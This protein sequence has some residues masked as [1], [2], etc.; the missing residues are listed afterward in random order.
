MYIATNKHDSAYCPQ[1]FAGKR[2]MVVGLG[3][4]GLSVVRFLQQRGVSFAV[5]D[6][7]VQPPGLTNLKEEFPDVPVFLGE[8]DPQVFASIDVLVVSPG[9]AVATPVIAACAQRGAEIIGDIEI[10]ARCNQ[11][12]VIAITGSNGKSTVTSLVA[13]MVRQAGYRVAAGANLGIPA[14][15]LLEQDAD[16]YVLELSSFQLET[17]TSLNASVSTILNISE[18]HMDRYA[19]LAD[20][21]RAKAAIFTG[22]GV[23]ISNDD[24]PIVTSLVASQPTVRN[25]LH[26]NWQH[27]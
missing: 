17:T 8:F 20:Y 3:K 22:N 2:V 4:T 24:D 7:R 6:S 1:I 11:K 13:E 23:I 14:L 19:S 12:A 9:V 26:F 5:A 15:D 18:D 10:F 16:I 21:A 25:V 27:L